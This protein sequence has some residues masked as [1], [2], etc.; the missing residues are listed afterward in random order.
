MIGAKKVQD[1]WDEPRAGEIWPSKVPTRRVT[2]MCLNERPKMA[3]MANYGPMLKMIDNWPT[4]TRMDENSLKLFSVKPQM[5]QLLLNCSIVWTMSNEIELDPS[6]C[7]TLQKIKAFFYKSCQIFH[8]N[9]HN[10]TNYR[11]VVLHDKLALVFL[12]QKSEPPRCFFLV[13]QT[14]IKEHD[15]HEPE[16]RSSA[17]NCRNPW[18]MARR[19]SGSSHFGS[20]HSKGLNHRD[21]RQG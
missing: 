6:T 13:A 12:C 20:F 4:W 15:N 10:T 17:Q 9:L 8:K 11:T 21:R 16:S 19:C 7:T 14:I 3:E 5:A 18:S 1:D 2:R